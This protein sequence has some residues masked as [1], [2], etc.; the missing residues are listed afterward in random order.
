[1]ARAIVWLRRDLRFYD[2]MALSIATQNFSEVYPVF[3]FDSKILTKLKNK[4]D[5]RVNFIF[6]TLMRLKKQH[7]LHIFYGDPA[8]LIPKLAK[9]FNVQEV[10]TNEDYE[11]YAKERDSKVAKALEKEKILFSSYKDTVIFSFRDIKNQTGTP[12]KVFT[13][14]KNKWIYELEQ[15]PESYA[16]RKIKTQN[17]KQNENCKENEITKI[18]QV[19]FNF[20]DLTDK[21]ELDPEKL[22]SLFKKKVDL[23]K[24]NRD[25]PALP[26]TSK[27]SV[28]LR[29]GTVN[30]R[31]LVRDFMP[32]NNEGRKVWLSELVW[33]EFYFAVLAHFP[34]VEKSAF[35]DYFKDIQWENDNKKFKAWCEGK[36]GVPIVDAGMRELNS[37][38]WM[39]NRVRMIVA[40]YL[41]KTLLIDWRLGEEYFA[42]KL[43]DFDLAANNGGW[44]WSASTGCDAAP[45]FRIFNPY[46]QSQKF[47]GEA[48]YIKKYVPELSAVPAKKI[49]DP[50]LWTPMDLMDWKI[51]IGKDYPAPI[52]DYKANRIKALAMYKK[53]KGEE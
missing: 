50:T 33:R 10:I 1:M 3:I 19:S 52:A 7:P 16:E 8:I 21:V 47:D 43:I 6:Q 37:T 36:T 22:L 35:L 24:A 9:E 41:C 53:A 39:H 31:M 17:I 13:P 25:Y 5:L 28:H 42:E 51:V 45:Y 38:G 26:N 49:H 2:N 29:F 46:T 48:H 14:Y 15:N 4:D 18:E 32:F 27:L 23:Y 20:I 12:Y 40:S 34:Y 44:Q 30:P 11:A